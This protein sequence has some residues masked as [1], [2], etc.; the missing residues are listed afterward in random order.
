MA[1]GAQEMTTASKRTLL[2]VFWR[3]ESLPALRTDAVNRGASIS[4][5]RLAIVGVAGGMVF[6]FVSEIISRNCAQKLSL[7]TQNFIL[8]KC[9]LPQKNAE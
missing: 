1:F 5:F 8:K 9:N 6:L 3:P 2:S 7:I 4:F